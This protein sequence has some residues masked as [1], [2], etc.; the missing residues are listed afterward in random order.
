MSG[1]VL[2]MIYIY[3]FYIHLYE[4]P[5]ALSLVF[6]AEE[7]KAWKGWL[8]YQMSLN[9]EEEKTHDRFENVGCSCY[10]LQHHLESANQIFFCFYV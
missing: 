1:L 7:I 2:F 6:L 10:N 9:L 3:F 4:N 5:Q 8:A